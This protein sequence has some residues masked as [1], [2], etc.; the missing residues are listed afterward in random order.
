MRLYLQTPPTGG[1]PRFCQLSVQPD[2]LEGWTLIRETGY[3]GYGGQVKRVRFGNRDSAVEAMTKARDDFVR[4][5]YRTVYS[6]G[7][8]APDG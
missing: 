8:S 6:E 4:R 2:L 7:L 1:R 5:G 3:Q